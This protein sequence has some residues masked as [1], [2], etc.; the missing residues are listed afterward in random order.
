METLLR[1]VEDNEGRV[2]AD[3]ACRPRTFLICGIAGILLACLLTAW[4]IQHSRLSLLVMLAIVSLA[5]FIFLSL[6]LATKILVGHELIINYHHEIAVLSGATLFLR[7]LHQPVLPYLDIFVLGLGVFLAC[8]RIGCLLV[9][10]C[11]GRPCRWG[12]IYHEHQAAAG[13][14]PYY[15]GI[16]LFPVQ[17]LES[18]FALVVVAFGI[19]MVLHGSLPGAA[20]T[21]YVIAYGFGRFCLEFLRGDPERPYLFGFSEAQWTSLIL[22]SL[23]VSSEL[24]RTLPMRPWHLGITLALLFLMVAVTLHRRFRRT[25]THRLLHP[26]H[27]REVANALE[28]ATTGQSWLKPE[29][30]V[31]RT[32]LGIQISSATRANS[33]PELCAHYCLSRR[34]QPLTFEAAAAL[35]K[36]VCQLRHHPRHFHLLPGNN[37]VFHYIVGSS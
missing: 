30:P 13:F 34:D 19:R 15:V 27:I 9:G 35:A 4:L 37:H 11:H 17:A 32:S 2:A 28:Y 10:C 31:G 3:V 6:A 7:L 8:G 20:F 25:P 12:I 23:T 26:R 21:W 18:L 24:S 14:T 16:P 1:S 29:I 36:I 22:M 5:V 33:A